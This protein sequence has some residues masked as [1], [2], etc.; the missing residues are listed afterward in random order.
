M[1]AISTDTAIAC[2]ALAGA[3]VAVVL[4][5]RY[6]LSSLPSKTSFEPTMPMPDR[7]TD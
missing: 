6:I 1:S 4:S 2:L 5:L 3:L 7:S